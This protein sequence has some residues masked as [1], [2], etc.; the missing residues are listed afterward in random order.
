MEKRHYNLKVENPSVMGFVVAVNPDAPLEERLVETTLGNMSFKFLRQSSTDTFYNAYSQP[1]Y[2]PRE[3]GGIAIGQ[4]SNTP[5]M[6]KLSKDG[7]LQIHKTPKG[8]EIYLF[9]ISAETAK[10][11]R[12]GAENWRALQSWV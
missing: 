9:E 5:I 11:L 7:T 3:D 8:K 12:E 4:K 10:K 2:V 1:Y 6:L